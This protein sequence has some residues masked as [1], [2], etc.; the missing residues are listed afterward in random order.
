MFNALAL[1]ALLPALVLRAFADPVPSTPGPGDVY[2]QG[3]SCVIE[4]SLDT[5]GT[6][7]TMNIELMTGDNTNMVHLTSTFSLSF[8]WKPF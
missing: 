1:F 5:N 6:W 8:L 7:T 3:A 2:N 4:W